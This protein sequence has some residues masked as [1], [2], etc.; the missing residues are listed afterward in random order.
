MSDTS[1]ATAVPAPV[2]APQAS[3]SVPPATDAVVQTMASTMASDNASG[4]LLTRI[5]RPI[6]VLWSLGSITAI[7]GLALGGHSE[8]VL[9]ALREVPDK[10]WDLI[11]YGVGIYAAGRTVEKTAGVLVGAFKK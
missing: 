8:P 2:E 5:Q 11:T 10:L 9:M 7:M 3:P 6:V 1:N 4:N